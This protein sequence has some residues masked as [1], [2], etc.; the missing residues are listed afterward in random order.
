M[1]SQAHVLSTNLRQLE[2]V[3]VSKEE[4]EVLGL[5]MQLLMPSGFGRTFGTWGF[6]I[7]RTPFRATRTFPLHW[8]APHATEDG[9][10]HA[11]FDVQDSE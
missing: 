5:L 8:K 11:C 6:H 7:R 2:T 9:R 4:K 3:A 10:E 1:F